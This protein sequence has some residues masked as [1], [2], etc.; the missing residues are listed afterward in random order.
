MHE[1][2]Y[3]NNRVKLNEG[4]SVRGYPPLKSGYLSEILWKA[5][6]PIFHKGRKVRVRAK[7]VSRIG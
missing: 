3:T 7:W 2:G 4:E 6:K 1:W 5:Y